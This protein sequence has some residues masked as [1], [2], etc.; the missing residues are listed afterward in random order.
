ML[1]FLKIHFCRNKGGWKT[2]VLFRLASIPWSIYVQKVSNRLV[3]AGKFGIFVASK[4]R[5]RHSKIEHGDAFCFI[6][7]V[8]VLPI[9]S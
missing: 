1:S 9:W 8:L 4:G 2:N 7:N 5:A 6:S 3:T